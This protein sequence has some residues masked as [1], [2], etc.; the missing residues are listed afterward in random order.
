LRPQL[1]VQI[2]PLGREGRMRRDT[3]SLFD[4]PFS[5]G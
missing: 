1:S 4:Y 3:S 5:T 2:Q